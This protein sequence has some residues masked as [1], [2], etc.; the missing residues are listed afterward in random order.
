IGYEFISF[1]KMMDMIKTGMDANEAMKKATGT[2]G[3]F[4][5]AVKVIDPREE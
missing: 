1:G 4:A 5:D 2:Y 3:R